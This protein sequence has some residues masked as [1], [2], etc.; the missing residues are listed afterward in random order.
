MSNR[1]FQE[2][3]YL[4][5]TNKIN[6]EYLFAETFEIL[7]SKYDKMLWSKESNKNGAMYVDM[8]ALR[9]KGIMKFYANAR[10]KKE[11][12]TCNKSDATSLEKRTGGNEQF[13][14]QNWEFAMGMY[15][16]SLSYAEQGSANIS[17]AYA[18]RSACFLHMKKY[19][20]CLVDIELA[21]KTGYPTH[22]MP[23]L[24]QREAECMK[25]IESDG[26]KS[27]DMALKLSFDPDEQ[28]PCMANVLKIDRDA[29][30]KLSLFANEDIDVGQT[31]VV[32]KAFTK[33]LYSKFG[34]RCSVCLKSNTNLIPCNKCTIA[35]FCSDECR[36][37]T[38]HEDECG[39]KFSDKTQ[40]N[41]IVMNEVRIMLMV[42]RMFPNI[43]DLIK[44]VEQAVQRYE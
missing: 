19:K 8:F 12:T 23:K 13:K 39:L 26:K 9:G 4:F 20:E 6:I 22:L 2:T 1:N 7:H 41:G 35:M 43:D 44:F 38:L 42:I 37:S 33:Y 14:K 17:L 25:L 36:N 18:N 21:R 34:L 15:N 27:D 16:E 28:F 3:I 29:D 5:I 10:S 32:E 11:N 40:I 30:G 31:I 24:D